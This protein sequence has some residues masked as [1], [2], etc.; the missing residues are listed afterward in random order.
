MLQITSVG[1]IW[2]HVSKPNPTSL[3]GV[4]SFYEPDYRVLHEARLSFKTNP[5]VLKPF[6]QGLV[7]EVFLQGILNPPKIPLFILVLI[8]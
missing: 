7:L 1:R 2:I 8:E 3:H 6:L 5:Q 4:R